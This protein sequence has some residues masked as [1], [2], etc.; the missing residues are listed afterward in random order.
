[1]ID[2][3]EFAGAKYRIVLDESEKLDPAREARVWYYRIPCTY[4]FISVHG[5]KTLAGFTNRRGVIAR[6]IEIPGVRVHQRGDREARVLFSPDCLDAVAKVLKARR[7]VV[8]SDEER[9]RR[10]ERMKSLRKTVAPAAP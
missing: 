1:M 5:P 6:L 10:A 7:R 2:L 8:L 3:K 9:I 4:G